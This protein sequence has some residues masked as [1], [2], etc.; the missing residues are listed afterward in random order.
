[1]QMADDWNRTRLQQA[2]ATRSPNIQALR[3]VQFTSTDRMPEPMLITQHQNQHPSRA[4]DG[5]SAFRQ[6]S[7]H[8]LEHSSIFPPLSETP[9]NRAFRMCTERP[10]WRGQE[11]TIAGL[12]IPLHLLHYEVLS[13]GHLLLITLDQW[14]FIG[15]RLGMQPTHGNPPRIPIQLAQQLQAWCCHHH[16]IFDVHHSRT[17]GPQQGPPSVPQ[18]SSGMFQ[19]KPGGH[20]MAGR[21][22][23]VGTNDPAELQNILSY[24]KLPSEE[25]YH[26]GISSDGIKKVELHRDFFARTLDSQEGFRSAI[27]NGAT[28]MPQQQRQQMGMINPR[29]EYDE[30]GTEPLDPMDVLD[31]SRRSD[32]GMGPARGPT[33]DAPQQQQQPEQQQVPGGPGLSGLMPFSLPTIE[34]QQHAMKT[35]QELRDK[36]KTWRE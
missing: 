22:S 24:A 3:D 10:A 8:S 31:T 34:T 36:L 14:T 13:V 28:G 5:L 15:A 25:L 23:L 26:R 17:I 9:F 32:A 30:Q 35:V 21:E 2:L 16:R 12:I 19:T 29:L 11:A 1:M 20:A 7:Q 4:V 33:A 6:P 18:G 27:K